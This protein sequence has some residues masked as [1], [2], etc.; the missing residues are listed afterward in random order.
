MET[1]AFYI[2]SFESEIETRLRFTRDFLR[3]MEM[4][5]RMYG[6]YPPMIIFKGKFGKILHDIVIKYNLNFGA[7]VEFIDYYDSEVIMKSDK[8][9]TMAEDKAHE[10]GIIYT[11]ETKFKPE[12]SV[13]IIKL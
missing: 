12:Y 3:E 5:K 4:F 11:K 6:E 13:K 1:S 8:E 7:T 2:H 9:I 10:F